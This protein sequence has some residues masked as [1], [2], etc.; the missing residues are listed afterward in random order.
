MVVM[1]M[2]MRRCWRWCWW[3]GFGFEEIH[4]F[5]PGYIGTGDMEF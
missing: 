2:V 5:F 1:V 4:W 3:W